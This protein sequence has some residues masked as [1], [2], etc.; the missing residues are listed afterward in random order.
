MTREPLRSSCITV[1]PTR[2]TAV[3]INC[4]M[5]KPYHILYMVRPMNVSLY[6]LPAFS[7]AIW[8]AIS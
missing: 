1:V 8:R 2:M 3:A 6:W 5:G 4:C 7:R